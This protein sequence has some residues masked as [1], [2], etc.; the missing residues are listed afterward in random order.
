M[1]YW[2]DCDMTDVEAA[3]ESRAQLDAEMAKALEESPAVQRAYSWPQAD[4]QGPEDFGREAPEWAQNL[5]F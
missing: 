4:P 2:K 1:G 5:P 3:Q